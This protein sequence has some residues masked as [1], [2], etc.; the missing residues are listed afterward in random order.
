MIKRPPFRKLRGY[1]FDPSLSLQSDTVEFNH[2]T[3]KVEWEDLVK[4]SIDGEATYP[5]GF[6]ESSGV[7]MGRVYVSPMQPI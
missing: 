4:R 5:I 2:I 3:Y 1:A 7:R 6:M